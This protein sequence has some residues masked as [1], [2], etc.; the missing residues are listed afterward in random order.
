L[1]TAGSPKRSTA[2]DAVIIDDGHNAAPI[3]QMI[4]PGHGEHRRR[5]IQ[6]AF[7]DCENLHAV[8][9]RTIV[10]ADFELVNRKKD[11]ERADSELIEIDEGFWSLV[12]VA[13]E[14]D[15]LPVP[16]RI[17]CI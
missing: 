7:L 3:H 13:K 12:L 8:D 15:G 4:E 6:V 11:A 10:F 17:V 5:Q 14:G 9:H 16:G 1:L 2:G